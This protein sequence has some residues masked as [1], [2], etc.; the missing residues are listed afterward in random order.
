MKMP[1]GHRRP[2]VLAAL[3]AVS[4]TA[5]DQGTK[6]LVDATVDR[7]HPVDLIFGVQI[8]N[9]R[10]NGV[11]FGLLGGASTLVLVLTLGTIVG[12]LAYFAARAREPGAWLAVGLVIGGAAGN[13]I[14]RIRLGAAIDFIDPPAWPAFNLADVAIVT[15]VALLGTLLFAPHSGGGSGE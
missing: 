9:V 1:G 6:Q 8:A 10:N 12:L 13:L 5:V 3:I 14:D 11:A 15:G 7:G 4:V 2:W